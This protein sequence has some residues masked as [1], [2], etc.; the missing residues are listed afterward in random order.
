M[1]MISDLKAKIK[2]AHVSE[3]NA[4]YKYELREF[5]DSAVSSFPITLYE[6]VVEMETEYGSESYKTGGIFVN[7]GKAIRFFDFL[8]ENLAT[9]QNLPYVIED[10]IS[11]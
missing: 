9:P 10:A 6:I 8:V 11:F 2:S 1:Q 4:S 5:T 3:E 7:L